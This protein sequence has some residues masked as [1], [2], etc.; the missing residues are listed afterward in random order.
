MPKCR[1]C[2]H[3]LR[4]L[5]SIGDCDQWDISVCSSSP[6]CDAFRPKRPTIGQ[7]LLCIV[8]CLAL[9]AFLWALDLWA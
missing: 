9:Q 5:L 7:G 2:Q 6:S 8:V 3:F 4:I 1:D